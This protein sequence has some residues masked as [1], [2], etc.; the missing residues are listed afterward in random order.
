M[1]AAIKPSVTNNS[2]FEKKKYGDDFPYVK[3]AEIDDA[4]NIKNAP[5]KAKIIVRTKIHLFKF[6][7]TFTLFFLI[8]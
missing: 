3:V 1:T 8:F 7:N 2:C 6:L 4:S 5:P